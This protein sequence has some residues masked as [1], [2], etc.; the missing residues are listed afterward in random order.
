LRLGAVKG[1]ERP[2]ADAGFARVRSQ[3]PAVEIPEQ[4]RHGARNAPDLLG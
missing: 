3:A 1:R 2:A 4:S